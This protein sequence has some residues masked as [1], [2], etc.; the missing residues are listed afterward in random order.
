MAQVNSAR[1]RVSWKDKRPL[2]FWRGAPTNKNM[3][4]PFNMTTIDRGI[5]VDKSQKNPDLIDAIFHCFLDRNV[6][7]HYPKGNFA[8]VSEHLAYKY[9][10]AMDGITATFPGYQWRL[11]SGCLT[12]KQDSTDTMWYYGA[13]KPWVHYVPIAKNLDGL[14][15][16]IL[17]L[18]ENDELAEQ[19]AINAY[20]FTENNLKPEHMYLYAYKVICAYTQAQ[21]N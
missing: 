15:D 6:Q 5:L 7:S 12:I 4:K 3:I 21:N 14:E 9:Q 18:R 19:I 17:W 8:S 1:H 16:L 2:L 13:I 20:E 11:Y 10:I